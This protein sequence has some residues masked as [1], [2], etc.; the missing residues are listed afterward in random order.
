MP[1]PVCMCV[2]VYIYTHIHTH[3]YIKTDYVPNVL[4]QF[5]STVKIKCE[6]IHAG[7]VNFGLENLN[8][9]YLNFVFTKTMF[10]HYHMRM[11]Q[12]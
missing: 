6:E 10:L 4:L 11:V 5:Y 1:H 3:I 12:I 2:C 9:K 7:W 8:C